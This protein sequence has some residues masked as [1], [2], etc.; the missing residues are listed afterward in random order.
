[1]GNRKKGRIFINERTWKRLTLRH[2]EKMI[3][4][5]ARLLNIR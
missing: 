3:E 5:W 1:V 4:M 2:L